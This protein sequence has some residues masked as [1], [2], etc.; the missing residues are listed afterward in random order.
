M[1]IITHTRAPSAVHLAVL[2]WTGTTQDGWGREMRSFPGNRHWLLAQ[3]CNASSIGHWLLRSP[4]RIWLVERRYAVCRLRSWWFRW[5]LAESREIEGAGP[6]VEKWREWVRKTAVERNH[7]T[8]SRRDRAGAHL[9][10]VHN[11][12]EPG[13]WPVY[14][15]QVSR[16]FKQLGR[17]RSTGSSVHEWRDITP[18][19]T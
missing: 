15:H 13:S 2:L 12:P 7:R 9:D 1:F 18:G 4:A 10:G 11:T 16:S 8:Q 6:T 3:L 14:T 5:F 17:A 19:F